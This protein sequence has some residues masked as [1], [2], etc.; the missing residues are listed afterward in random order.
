MSVSQMRILG[1]DVAKAKLDIALLLPDGKFRSEV[2]PNTPEGFEKLAV[3]L[4]RNDAAQVHACME[5]TGIYW[6]SAAAFLAEK[7]HAVSVVNPAQIKAFG[8]AALSR[9]KTDKKDARLIARFCAERRP[10]LWEPSP[11]VP[12]ELRS[13]VM[14]RD[15]LERMRTQEMNRLHVARAEVQQSVKRHIS[16]LEREIKEIDSE[17]QRKTDGDTSLKKQ[18]EL[19]N[20]VPGLGVKTIPVLLSFFSGKRFSNPRQAA[21]YAGLDPRQHESG[22]S[23]RR[24]PR[25][26]KMG[27]AFLR[28]TL[29]MPAMVAVSR[30]EWG[31]AFKARL[32]ANGKPPMVIICAM[33]RKLVHVT[34]GILKSGKMFDPALH[35]A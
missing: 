32:A 31:K 6:E 15:A 1:I 17:I 10:P 3:W 9:T 4:E 5:A 24:K 20:S 12:A 21:A 27:H 34:V 11:P 14:R 13:L 8:S 29:Y 30:T 26:S 22:S 2:I 16:Y 35:G 25:I 7:G 23:V 19:L 18:R 33:M 28:K